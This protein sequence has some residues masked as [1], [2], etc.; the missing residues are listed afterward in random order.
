MQEFT[1]SNHRGKKT[2]DNNSGGSQIDMVIDRRD[3][4]IN[5]CEVKFYHAPFS[6][7]KKYAAALDTKV[8][9]FQQQIKTRKHVFL[10]LISTFGIHKNE[11]SIGLVDNRVL[12]DDLFIKFNYE[13]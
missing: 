12:M 9:A 3:N 2:K 11:H 8:H 7:G 10:T 6:I 5:L 13:A 1:A 4:A